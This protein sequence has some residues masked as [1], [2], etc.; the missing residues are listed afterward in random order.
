MGENDRTLG[1]IGGAGVGAAAELYI[2][3][4][5]RFRAATATL[6]QIAIW[7]LPLSDEL[8]R[9]F[10]GSGADPAAV[11]Q[12]EALVAESVDRLAAAGATVIAMPCNALARVGARE[13]ERA[14]L[15]FVDMIAATVEAV[16]ALG[17][18]EATLLATATTYAAGNYDGHGVEMIE[19]APQQRAEL[20]GLIARLGE[21]PQPTGAEL[22]GLIERVRRPGTAVVIGCTDI[23]GLIDP[24][25][26]G[27][28]GPVV[29]SLACLAERCAQALGAPALLGDRG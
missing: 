23:C 9:S 10:L 15:P 21:G 24:G 4:C 20:A 3:V 18:D 12:A 6:P 28:G 14:G 25:A 26:A 2:D 27:A 7:N 16:A 13:S 5:A 17:H 1:I 29:D 22:L 8:E 19:P 11:A